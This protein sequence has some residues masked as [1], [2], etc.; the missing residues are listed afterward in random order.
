M[1]NFAPVQLPPDAYVDEYIIEVFCFIGQDCPPTPYYS[2]VRGKSHLWFS[3]ANGE[4]LNELIAQGEF[5]AFDFLKS[6]QRK[7]PSPNAAP[8]TT[9][10]APAVTGPASKG[11]IIQIAG[12]TI[13]LPDNA[14]I[15]AFIVSIYCRDSCAKAPLYRI[16]LSD[17]S[18]FEVSAVD[19]KIWTERPNSQNSQEADA[20]RTVKASLSL[21]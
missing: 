8:P 6:L 17:R 2:I 5:G 9:V 12:K 16:A 20:F 14:Y 13:K 19:G 15:D 10:P 18:W 1:G 7:V 3:A 11:A 21:K 4:V